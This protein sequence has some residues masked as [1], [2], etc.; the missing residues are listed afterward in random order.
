M[1]QLGS[2]SPV[3]G[4]AWQVLPEQVPVPQ[5]AF[6]A[7]AL[8]SQSV[9]QTSPRWH[10]VPAC[11]SHEHAPFA[12]VPPPHSLF[13][14]VGYLKARSFRRRHVMNARRDG[15][16][17]S[18]QVQ[19][20]AEVFTEMTSEGSRSHDPGSLRGLSD[21]RGMLFSLVAEDASVSDDPRIEALLAWAVNGTLEATADYLGTT[22]AEAEERVDAGLELLLSRTPAPIGAVLMRLFGMSDEEIARACGTSTANIRMRVSRAIPVLRDLVSRKLRAA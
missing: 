10:A 13:F 20:D 14:E 4:A 17:A 22:A 3:G 7:E 18:Q 6:S 19:L 5:S 16:T 12:Q 21:L 9:H 2:N 8:P 1:M 15:T 11:G